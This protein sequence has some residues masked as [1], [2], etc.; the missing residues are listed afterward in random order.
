MPGLFGNIGLPFGDNEPENDGLPDLDELRNQWEGL[1]QERERL[2]RM[3]AQQR[4][5]AHRAEMEQRINELM[6]DYENDEPFNAEDAH[7]ALDPE[8]QAEQVPD[9][10]EANDNARGG[11]V[12][13][14]VDEGMNYT[15]TLSYG[16]SPS[17]YDKDKNKLDI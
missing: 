4:A 11:Y 2:R 15:T 9:N 10:D 7:Q 5:E 13:W 14:G 3:Q 6:D 1:N 12:E 17:E 16:Y 8:P